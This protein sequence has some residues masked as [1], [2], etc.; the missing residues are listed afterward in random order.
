M[1][2][3]LDNSIIGRLADIERGIKQQNTMLQ[4]DTDSIPKVIALCKEHGIELCASDDA[5]A[6]IEKLAVT[7]PEYRDKLMGHLRSFHLLPI[8][9]H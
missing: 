1:R 3:Y 2:T 6:E 4:E 8:R 5:G 7:N 9:H